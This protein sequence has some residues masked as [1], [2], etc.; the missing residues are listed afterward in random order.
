MH[1]HHPGGYLVDRV[2]D[3]R[4]LARLH[5]GSARSYPTSTTATCGKERKA[6]GPE[7]DLRVLG[8]KCYEALLTKDSDWSYGQPRI[9]QPRSLP[10]QPRG[11][12]PDCLG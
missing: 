9:D 2:V 10:A 4:D 8:E 12:A 5:T 11:G 7:T 6:Q 1:V 3:K